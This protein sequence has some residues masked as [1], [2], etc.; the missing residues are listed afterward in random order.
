[1]K[2]KEK[3]SFVIM[4]YDMRLYKNV[5]LRSEVVEIVVLCNVFEQFPY[6]EMN[7]SLNISILLR[8]NVHYLCCFLY[9]RHARSH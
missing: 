5:C 8:L 4:S 9:S 1:M 7:V 3:P 2:K 6:A